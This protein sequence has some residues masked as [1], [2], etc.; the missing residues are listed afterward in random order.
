MEVKISG[1]KEQKNKIENELGDPEIYSNMSK[2]QETEKKYNHT[3]SE[4]KAAEAQYEKVFEQ[5]MEFGD[6]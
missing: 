6:Q 1:L 4:L 3:V 5:L 2:F